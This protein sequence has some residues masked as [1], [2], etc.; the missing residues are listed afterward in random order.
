[1]KIMKFWLPVAVLSLLAG[2]W[3]ALSTPDQAPQVTFSTLDG[4]RLTLADLHGKVVLVNFWAT[5]CPGCVKEMPQI[6][7]T[8]HQYHAKGFETVAV[9]MSY[10]PPNHVSSFAQK[11]ALPFTVALDADGAAAQAFGEVQVT[12]TSFV[13]DRNGRIVQRVI[14]ELNFKQLHGWLDEVL[15]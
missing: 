5:S 10:D 9:A 15:K 7:E 14:G 8:W 13:I 1:M 12:P 4:K 11:F 2:L 3:F 6:T